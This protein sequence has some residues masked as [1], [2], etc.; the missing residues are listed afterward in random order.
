V[1]VALVALLIAAA[2]LGA[3]TALTRAGAGWQDAHLAAA[4]A[5]WG[6]LIVLIAT[7]GTP[8]VGAIGTEPK[9]ATIEAGG[10]R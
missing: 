10:S 8:P 5:L 3:A 9:R 7:S 6:V 4:A 1:R 2:A